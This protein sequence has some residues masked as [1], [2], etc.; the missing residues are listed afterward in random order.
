[1]QNP[2]MPARG[3]Q[4]PAVAAALSFF[5]PGA[6]QWYAG[7]RRAARIY[8]IP[9]VVI[10]IALGLRVTGGIE[11]LAFDLLAPDFAL[12]IIALVVLTGLWRVAPS[13]C[14]P[15]G[16]SASFDGHW[17]ASLGRPPRRP[18]PRHHATPHL[19][20]RLLQRGK[21]DLCGLGRGDAG[22]DA[23]RVVGTW[24]D[25]GA[26]RP[27]FADPG[28]TPDPTDAPT[29]SKRINVLLLGVDSARAQPRP[30]RPIM[31]ISV[32]P[33]SKTVAM[34]SIPATSPTSGPTDGFHGKINSP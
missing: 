2:A 34:V 10:A 20:L 7:A 30:D 28:T 12:T 3:G 15:A 27:R 32:D 14:H 8:G 16:G 5:L 9:V 23:E 17:R 33:D 13:P 22:A 26:G 25:A 29:A 31:L 6:G 18:G 24:G 21:P 11:R 1:M 19:C 4:S